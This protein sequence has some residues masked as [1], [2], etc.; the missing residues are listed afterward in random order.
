MQEQEGIPQ[1]Q[2]QASN[3]A[4]NSDPREQY[5]GQETYDYERPYDEG[6]NGLHMDDM[7]AREREKLQPRQSGIWQSLAKLIAFLVVVAVFIFVAFLSGL[8][9][10]WF[11]WLIL[12]LHL[13]FGCANTASLFGYGDRDNASL[14]TS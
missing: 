14:S 2:E 11:L 5:S 13:L 12:S 8:L 3:Y 9:T 4:I 6:Y 7:R 10:S 1:S